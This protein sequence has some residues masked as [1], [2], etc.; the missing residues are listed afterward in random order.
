MTVFS[1]E[2]TDKIWKFCLKEELEIFKLA[3]LNIKEKKLP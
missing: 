3:F 1:S 2:T